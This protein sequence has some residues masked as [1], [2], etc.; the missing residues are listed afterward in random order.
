[1]RTHR[2][3]Q[4]HHAAIQK[5]YYSNMI[6]QHSPTQPCG[7]GEASFWERVLQQVLMVPMNST[8]V[9]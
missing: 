4:T 7:F 5:L 2:T 6:V 3:T 1:M 8:N 9:V